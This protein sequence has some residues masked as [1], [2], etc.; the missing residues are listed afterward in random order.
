MPIKMKPKRAPVT[1]WRMA[2]ALL[3]TGLWLAGNA[4]AGSLHH[5]DCE[6]P[7]EDVQVCWDAIGD[8][9]EEFAPFPDVHLLPIAWQRQGTPQLLTDYSRAVF[10]QLLPSG[11]AD[12]LTQEWHAAAN[13]EEAMSLARLHQWALTLWISPRVLRESSSVSPG[14]VDW[15]I[16]LIKH[17]KLLR[18]LR[19]RVESRPTRAGKGVE[20]G[21]TV[22]ALLLATGAVTAAPIGS[23]AT[24]AGTV[25]MSPS[26][27]PEAGRSLELMT[28]FAVRQVLT[29]FKYPMEQLRSGS[30]P[31]PAAQKASGWVNQLFSPK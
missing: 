1:P 11:F 4:W 23:A 17:N 6:N 15:D 28:E 19:V 12:N 14:L 13:L 27:P 2:T 24:V 31:T 8:A 25:A 10:R 30:T 16:Y 9:G 21:T 29:S 3:W 7:V 5:N 20:T 22:G 26:H 18:T